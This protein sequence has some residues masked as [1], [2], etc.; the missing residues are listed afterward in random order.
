MS[1]WKRSVAPNAPA[2]CAAMN[3]GASA[4]RMP[5]KVFVIERA[6]VTAGLANEVDAV[7][8]YAAIMRRL[9]LSPVGGDCSA[10]DHASV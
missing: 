7:N 4:G 8:Q 6:R 10:I 9:H 2:N 5:E 1:H 3:S